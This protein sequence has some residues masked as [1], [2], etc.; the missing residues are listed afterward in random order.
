MLLDINLARRS[1]SCL[2]AL[3]L[4]EWDVTTN[5]ATI[6]ELA[7]PTA[8]GLR[9]AEQFCVVV[10]L[11]WA[12]MLAAYPNWLIDSRG[13][14]VA[15]DFVGEW[16]AGQLVLQGHPADAYN[17]AIHKQ[18]ETELVGYDFG[19]DFPWSYPPPFLFFIGELARLPYFPAF[20]V[21]IAATWVG[22]ALVLRAI[23]GHRLGFLL[24]AAFPA[25][26]FN[27]AVGQNGFL[28]AALIG[29]TLLFLNKRPVL[30]GV[31]LGMLT[32]KP[33]LGIIFPLA[34][35]VSGHWR[36]FATAAIVSIAM[37][38]AS[39]IVFGSATWEAFFQGTAM[40]AKVVL[41]NGV[42]FGKL[43]S[44]FGFVRVIG[45]TETMA[46]TIQIFAA[47]A[48]TVGVLILWH[49]PVMFELK[50]AAL[51]IATLF[52]TP[53]VYIYDLTILAVPTGFLISLGLRTGFWPGEPAALIAAAIAVLLFPQ[54]GM[55]TGLLAMVIIAALI[56]RR[57]WLSGTTGCFHGEP[58]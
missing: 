51:S 48:C 56:L 42:G 43:H 8:V 47:F 16:T 58:R 18:A 11:I 26:M 31:L 2:S 52:I 3:I 38:L 39:L 35:V 34:L 15:N 32:Y 10:A 36:A 14:A 23:V 46:W 29:G 37:A 22:F 1:L 27:I 33:Q 50:A 17:W 9:R 5:P 28:T 53:Y 57:L 30:A 6:T 41:G 19:G 24:A 21:W 7:R 40:L 49:R 55:P 44:L 4:N 12:V 25:T 20:A 13:F 45:G 54:I